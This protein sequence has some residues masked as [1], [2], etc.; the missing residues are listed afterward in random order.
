MSAIELL[1]TYTTSLLGGL[2]LGVAAMWLLFSLGRVAG[3]SGI[4]WAS[5]LGLTGSGA[6]FL[7]RGYSLAGSSFTP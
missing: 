4:V 7:W 1:E 2:T 3:I 6:V 5:W